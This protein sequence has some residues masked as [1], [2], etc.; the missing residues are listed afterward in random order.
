MSRDDGFAVAEQIREQVGLDLTSWETAVELATTTE[1]REGQR[2]LI[3]K[4]KDAE[5]G[6]WV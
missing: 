4:F 5:T 3:P 1:V 2:S 6:K